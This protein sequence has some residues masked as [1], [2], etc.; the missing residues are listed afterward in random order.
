MLLLHVSSTVLFLNLLLLALMQVLPQGCLSK[1]L[2][3]SVLSSPS[4]SL[5]G[6]VL[7]P[8]SSSLAGS[9]PGIP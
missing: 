8:A 9:A 5:A 3:G 1:S 4:S 2:A 7:G 6:S